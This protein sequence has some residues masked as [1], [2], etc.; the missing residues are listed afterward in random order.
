MSSEAPQ[1]KILLVD[2]EPNWLNLMEKKLKP[3][4]TTTHRAQNGLEALRLLRKQSFDLVIT[5][6]DMPYM[7]GL[8]LLSWIRSRA[9]QVPVIVFFSGLIGGDLTPEEL[10]RVGASGVLEKKHAR[11]RLVPLVK[12]ILFSGRA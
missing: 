11:T 6:T 2:D 12:K 9:V 8:S 10:E 3:L 7:D 4:G 1:P 5:D